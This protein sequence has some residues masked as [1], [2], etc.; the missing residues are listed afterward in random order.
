MG[1][2]WG[3]KR[4][5]QAAM[6]AQLA[7]QAKQIERLVGVVETTLSALDRLGRTVQLLNARVETLERHREPMH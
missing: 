2:G 3:M 1:W 4:I 7:Q 6:V 5:D